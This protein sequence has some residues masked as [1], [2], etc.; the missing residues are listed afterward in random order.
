MSLPCHAGERRDGE[1]SDCSVKGE[2]RIQPVKNSF[3]LASVEKAKKSA[4]GKKALATKVPAKKAS[5]VKKA[6]AVKAKTPVKAKKAP[7]KKPKRIKSPVK[8]A[9]K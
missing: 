9:K 6:K 7:A 2:D 4:T 5:L 1:G 3:K 8:K